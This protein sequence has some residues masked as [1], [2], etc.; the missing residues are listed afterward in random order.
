M[1][2]Y[3]NSIAIILIA[4]LLAVASGYANG[5]DDHLSFITVESPSPQ[6]KA[7]LLEQWQGLPKH[8]RKKVASEIV[9]GRRLG[10][11]ST[12]TVQ[13]IG[14]YTQ[15]TGN[16]DDGK[17]KRFFHLRQTDLMGARLFWSVLL[18]PEDETFKIL[19]HINPGKDSSWLK[20]GS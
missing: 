12:G 10:L 8:L 6:A 20:L 15:R 4:S 7:R 5:E 16:G 19:Y 14:A 2:K 18:N 11:S 3:A 17:P 13:L 9:T 1:V